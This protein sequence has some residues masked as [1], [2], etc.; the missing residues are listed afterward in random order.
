MPV[1]S[2][3]PEGVTIGDLLSNSTMYD[4]PPYQRDFSWTE[5]Q[6][7]TFWNDIQG[8]K[9]DEGHFFGSM[10]FQSSKEDKKIKRVQIIDGQQRFATVTILLAVIRDLFYKS[11][12]ADIEDD[13][14]TQQ[15]IVKEKTKDERINKLTLNLRNKKFFYHCIQLSP[16]GQH[17][18]IDYKT[19]ED[20][21][22]QFNGISTTDRLIEKAYNFF[23]EKI[24]EELQTKDS[25]EKKI[26]YLTDL[27]GLVHYS[28]GEEIE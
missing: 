15:Y 27:S 26:K 2:F 6:I 20:F 16:Y 19:F 17:N 5:T 10:L 4:V 12:I 13:T 22:K 23:K 3:I 7:E 25:V 18:K 28:N 21:E 9:E 1:E 24:E 11:E 14:L 8:L